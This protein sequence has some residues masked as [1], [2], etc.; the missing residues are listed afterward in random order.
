MSFKKIDSRLNLPLEE[1][2]ILKFWR[3]NNIFKQTLEKDSP[4]GNFVFF[5]GPPTA[6]GKP[7]IHHVLARSFKDLFARYKTM[8]GF[9]VKR[10]A[11]WDTHGLPVELQVEKELGISGKGQIEDIVSGDKRASVEK[12]N[13]LCRESVW[14]YKEE[15]EKLTERMAYWVDMEDPY[16]TYEPKYIESV[17]SLIGEIDK[18]GLLYKG[19]K[20]VPYCPRCG[21]ALSSHEVAQGYQNIKEESVYVKIKSK[22]EDVFFLVWTT[23][24]WT[25]AGNAALAFSPNVEYARAKLNNEEYIIAL[26]R[27][28]A[29]LGAEAEIVEKGLDGEAII[30]RYNCGEEPDYEAIYADGEGYSEAG[31]RAYQLITADYVSDHDGTG[32][33]HIAPAFGADDYIYGFQQNRI[34]VLKTVDEKGTEMAGAGKGKFVKDADNDVKEDLRARDILFKVESVKHDYPFCWRCDSPLIYMAR[35]SWYIAMSKVR[36][37]LLKNNEDINWNPGYLKNGR[38]GNWLENIQDWAISRDRYWGTPLPIWECDKCQKYKVVTSLEEIKNV[39]PHKPEIDGVIFDCE[40]GGKMK[41]TPEVMDVWLDSGAMPYAQYHVP[42]ENVE[43]QKSQFP[44]DFIC[45]AVDQTRGWFYTLL[46]LS[47][48]TSNTSSYKNVIST[49]HVLDAHGKKMSKSKGNIIEPSEAF[50][51][52]GADVIRYFFYSTNQPGEPKLFNDKEVISVSRNLFMTLWNVYSFFMT[53]ASIDGWKPDKVE[54]QK[55]KVKSPM[56]EVESVLDEWILAKLQ[57][58]INQVSEGLDKFDPYKPSNQIID[59]VGELSTWYVRRSRRRFWKSESDSDKESA[60]HTLYYVLISLTKILA[61]MAPMFA[62]TVYQGLRDESDPESVHLTDFPNQSKFDQKILDE[63]SEA[64]NIVEE[65]LSKRAEAKIKVRQPLNSISTAVTL[66]PE[67]AEIILEEVNV[68]KVIA[69]DSGGT[70][71]DIN[72]TPE[73]KL[74]GLARELVRSIQALRKNAGFEVE[75]RIEVLYDTDSEEL[76][77]TFEKFHDLIS[78]EVLAVSIKSNRSDSGYSEDLLI[79]GA[80]IWINVSKTN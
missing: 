54:T 40:C 47:T 64:R 79:D 13:K 52:Y 75:N 19:H 30:E 45:E 2:N 77:E 59:F 46:A 53:Y 29:V 72:I 7:G 76:L 4:E 16:I 24:P 34:K 36:E 3:E 50:G 37:E 51:K 49:G 68:K 33:V 20:V 35:D 22:K 31:E 10:K 43:L 5:E 1:E 9:N 14:K 15:W 12:F 62:E 71:L 66:R 25:L 41:R 32:I 18:K 70:E 73:L 69:K 42:F 80:S 11:G 55:S 17:W 26:N 61:P 67:F 23:T 39:E 56:V 57:E 28:E 21:T 27:V 78:R 60:Y 8:K 65:G 63:M 74:E 6:N 48:I 44:A 58:L 38:F